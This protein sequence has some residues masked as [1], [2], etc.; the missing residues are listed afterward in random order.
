[1]CEYIKREEYN[2][3]V[4]ISTIRHLRCRRRRRRWRSP[5]NFVFT[6]LEKKLSCRRRFQRLIYECAIYVIVFGITRVCRMVDNTIAGE[7][8]G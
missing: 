3:I 8:G 7:R 6:S 4:P 2:I 1:V 5:L